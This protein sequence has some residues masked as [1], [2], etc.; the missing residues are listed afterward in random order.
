MRPCGGVTNFLR[1]AEAAGW[2]TVFLG[3]AVSVEEMI[4]AAADVRRR[5]WS[6]SRTGSRRRQGSACSVSLPKPPLSCTSKGV[7]FAFG[8]TPPVVE[9]VRRIGFF[10]R[11]L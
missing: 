1:L 10:E 7:R 11:D 6:A 5:T 3:P 2:R 4:S 8:G 9:R